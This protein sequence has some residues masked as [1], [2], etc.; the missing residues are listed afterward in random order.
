MVKLMNGKVMFKPTIIKV[1]ME[2]LMIIKL[3]M[4][5]PTKNYKKL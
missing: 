1:I 2:K 5:R 3:I 4:A